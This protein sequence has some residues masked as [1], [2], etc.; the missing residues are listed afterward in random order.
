MDPWPTR[1]N[2][3]PPRH[4]RVSG[5]PRHASELD[6]RFRG[7]DVVGVIFRRANWDNS[8]P[9]LPSPAPDLSISCYRVSVEDDPVGG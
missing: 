3:N 8:A 5:G 2:E 7:N 9:K 4:P 1:G 6:S